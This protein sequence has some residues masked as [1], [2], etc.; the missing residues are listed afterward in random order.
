MPEL[1]VKK[2]DKRREVRN[3]CGLWMEH[4]PTIIS[5][6]PGEPIP[7]SPPFFYD[8]RDSQPH[9]FTASMPRAVRSHPTLALII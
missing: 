9:G 3:V 8:G 4:L 7:T 5:N 6:V 2:P 1:R